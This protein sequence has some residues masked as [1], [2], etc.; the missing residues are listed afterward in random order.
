MAKKFILKNCVTTVNGVDLSDHISS[1]ELSLKKA[2][3]DT[4][5]FQGG[6]KEHQAGLSDDEIT[7]E[8]QQDFGAA[9]V[10]QTLSP[11]YD[12]E[13][14]FIVTVKPTASGVS[15]TNP[16][17]S[18]TCLLLEY[19]PLSGKVG[20]LSTVKVKF[21]TQRTGITYATS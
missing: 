11:L 17:Y 4:T 8:F 2:D 5:N 14:E 6:G 9:E 13:N 10:N 7:V 16:L 18:A 20:D 21:V 12:N 15:A 1:V 19:L 3:I